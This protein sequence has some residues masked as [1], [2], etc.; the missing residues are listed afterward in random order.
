M[1]A[2]GVLER[3]L[4]LKLHIDKLQ[5]LAFKHEVFAGGGNILHLHISRP[6]SEL[7]GDEV[8]M[9]H[10]HIGAFPQGFDAVQL[11]VFY[12]DVLGI[13]QGGPAKLRH[14]AVFDMQAIVVPE[15]VAQI[16]ETIHS[17]HVAAFFE[18][19]FSVCR[20]IEAAA[21]HA[22]VAATVKGPLFVKN[23]VLDNMHSYASK[24][25]ATVLMCCEMASFWGQFAS[26]L[27]QPIQSDALALSIA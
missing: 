22:G 19:A 17:F 4:P 24:T 10:G 6:P 20:A 14:F 5:V 16:K 3:I 21:S 12:A 25:S 26:Q 27:P 2:F 1:Q 11:S 9:L 15:G 8:A 13:P 18:S 23:L 7:G